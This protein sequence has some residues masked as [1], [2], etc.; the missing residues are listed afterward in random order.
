[1][2]Q[3]ELSRAFL[4]PLAATYAISL[5]LALLVGFYVGFPLMGL[6]EGPLEN[7]Q[8]V[9]LLIS[10]AVFGMAVARL[11]GAPRMTAVG[12]VVLCLVFYLRELELPVT[13]AFTA[14]LDS[15]AFRWHEAFAILAFLVPYVWMNR[16]FIPAQWTYVRSGQCWPFL[17]AAAWMLIGDAMDKVSPTVAG[18]FIEE[19]AELNG[20]LTL[21]LVAYAF[22]RKRQIA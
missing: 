2:I 8:E 9:V 12:A 7:M 21:L 13:G 14:Y 18:G 22:S 4:R 10:A 3:L 5:L 6:E 15:K 16:R 1:M 11:N 19:C 20:Y 17:L